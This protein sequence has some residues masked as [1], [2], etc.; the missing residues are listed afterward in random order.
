MIRAA[1]SHDAT[2]VHALVQEAYRHWVP[3]LGRVPGPMRDDYERRIAAAQVWVLEMAGEIVG[4]V[5]LE[6]QPAHLLL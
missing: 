4:V 6:E 3:R 5:V 1:H 2:A